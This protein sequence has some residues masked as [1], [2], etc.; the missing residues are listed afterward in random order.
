MWE[1]ENKISYLWVDLKKHIWF[2]YCE[3]ESKYRLK[4]QESLPHVI[5]LKEFISQSF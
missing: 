1:F 4:G 3:K 2:D 5:D